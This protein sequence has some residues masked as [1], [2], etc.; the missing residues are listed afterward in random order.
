MIGGIIMSRSFDDV[1]AERLN[2]IHEI[3]L[4]KA[5]PSSVANEIYEILKDNQIYDES[6]LISWITENLGLNDPALIQQG[7]DQLVAEKRLIK[8]EKAGK[9]FY[10]KFTQL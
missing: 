7:I 6:E 10:R 9:I 4:A 1:I 5:L 3:R 8:V 2:K